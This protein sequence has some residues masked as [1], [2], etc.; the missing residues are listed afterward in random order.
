[1]PISIHKLHLSL[2]VKTFQFPGGEI[3]V[4]LD[5]NNLNYRATTAP[6]QTIVTS[7][8]VEVCPLYDC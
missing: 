7:V 5:N 8:L 2:D 4:K 3:G 6:Y 1:M